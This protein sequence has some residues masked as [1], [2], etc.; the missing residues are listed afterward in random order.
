M[1]GSIPD[2]INCDEAFAGYEAY[3]VLISSFDSWGKKYPLYFIT[4]GGGTNVL[5][6][7]LSIPFIAL[8]GLETWVIRL[9][10]L[11][12]SLISVFVFYR[13]LK[14][15]YNKQTAYLGLFIIAIMP[16]HI[17]LSRWGFHGNIAPAFYLIAFYFY[18]KA[19][20]NI[21]NIWLAMFFW[22]LGCYTY[23]PIIAF[24]L[25]SV[26]I[27]SLY[28]LLYNKKDKLLWYNLIGSSLLF[29]I[30]VFP[31]FLL[32]LI[33]NFNY[34]EINNSYFSIPKLPGWRGNE[35]NFSNIGQNLIILFNLLV[36]QTDNMIW[37]TINRFGLFYYI[38]IPFILVG[39]FQTAKNAY[40][41]IKNHK[42]IYNTSIIS[43]F[44]FGILYTSLFP[45]YSS[46][47]VNFLFFFITIFI[48]IGISVF[49]KNKIVFLAIIFLY[50]CFFVDFERVYFGNYNMLAKDNFSI[51][52]KEALK[53][54]EK[55]H[56]QTNKEIHI[57][58]QQS[59]VT[60]LLFYNK[61]DNIAYKNTIIWKNY[62]SAYLYAESFL[63]YKFFT[64]YDNINIQ[65][66]II[67]I[68]PRYTR[69]VFTD[70]LK[71]SNY[72]IKLFGDYIVVF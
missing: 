1:F 58:Y 71:N 69:Q 36:K 8:F 64:P 57:L 26:F 21:K 14:I 15:I 25:G 12:F 17:I 67:Y 19:L 65:K 2:G 70:A 28:L 23:D 31:V 33:N 42:I 27:S 3:S 13:L 44:F 66:D 7:Y 46:N 22:G 45:A 63:Y 5:Y 34:E 68:A 59:E 54:A 29:A 10:Q 60:K 48:T 53:E 11:I 6:S 43:F 72:Q 37:N 35:V 62:P 4:G 38:S 9:P 49:I 32:F 56:L 41:E 52:F 30:V 39:L 47:R 55:Q 18:C 40:I 61:I 50:F 51:K 16:W 20:K 24:I